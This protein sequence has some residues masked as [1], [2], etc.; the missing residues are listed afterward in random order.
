MTAGL[1]APNPAKSY[2]IWKKGGAIWDSVKDQ[3]VG[4]CPGLSRLGPKCNHKYPCK[5]EA[6][7]ELTGRE[8]GKGL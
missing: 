6:G 7:G 3:E 2:F 4:D 8:E 5:R 1:S